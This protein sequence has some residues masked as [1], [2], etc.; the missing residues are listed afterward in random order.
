[1]DINII[2]WIGISALSVTLSL[3]ALYYA[4]KRTTYNEE[5][6]DVAKQSLKV[7]RKSLKLRELMLKESRKYWDS[8]AKRAKDVSRRVLE[9]MTEEE[10][11]KELIRKRTERER[12][13]NKS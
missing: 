8:W 3:V 7:Q 10:L 11:E 1:M 2:A 12:R 4:L 13:N 9:Q 5:T 6:L